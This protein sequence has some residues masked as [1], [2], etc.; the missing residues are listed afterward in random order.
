M[1]SHLLC[2]GDMLGYK[3]DNHIFSPLNCVILQYVIKFINQLFSLKNLI[4]NIAEVIL[5][6]GSIR[7][8]IVSVFNVKAKAIICAHWAESVLNIC[9]YSIDLSP[10]LNTHSKIII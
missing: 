8:T 3:T 10:E 5:L 4:K 2:N 9:V 7:K 1:M 6:I